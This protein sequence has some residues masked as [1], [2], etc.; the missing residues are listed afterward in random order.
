VKVK[1]SIFNLEKSKQIAEMEARFDIV[2]KEKENQILKQNIQLQY[3]NLW[4]LFIG[5]ALVILLSVMLFY[6][7]RFKNKSLRQKTLLLEQEGQ[8]KE[9]EKSRIEDQLFAEQEINKLQT[10]KLEQQNRELS[11]RILH[12]INKNEAMNNILSEI[13]QLSKTG[14]NEISGCYGK[15]KRIVN[16]NINF[17]KEWHQF[18]LHFEEVNPGF[19]YNL[20]QKFPT[21]T[22]SELKLC[23]YYRIN[24]DTKEI[25]RL[26]NVTN[27]AIQKGRHR[28]R[29]KMDIP[30][31]IEI[32]DFMSTF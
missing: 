8:L 32:S 7:S 9:L 4:L 20:H 1:D 10:E 19:F 12:A 31:E 23:A 11:T 15:V 2:K 28:L 6:Y 24:L 26:L 5:L 13:E 3:R 16:D 29:K 21:L 22:Q 25:A 18:K 30:S 17:D 27:A 14:N